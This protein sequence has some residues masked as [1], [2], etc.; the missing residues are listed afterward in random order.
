MTTLGE[1][2]SARDVE[3]MGIFG[4]YPLPFEAQGKPLRGGERRGNNEGWIALG[5]RGSSRG[6]FTTS[7]EP[8]LPNAV[9]VPRGAQSGLAVEKRLD[10]SVR[11]DIYVGRGDWVPD[12]AGAAQV[13]NG[14]CRTMLK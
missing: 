11:E 3:A 8:S 14:K 1:A 9:V 4:T 12:D 5:K 2:Q 6:R 13:I 10:S 7:G